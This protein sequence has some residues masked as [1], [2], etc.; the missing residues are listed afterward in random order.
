MTTRN[1]NTAIGLLVTVAALAAA[2]AADRHAQAAGPVDRAPTCTTMFQPDSIAIRQEPVT[3]G[4][5]LSDDIGRI[6]AVMPPE[7]SG[8]RVNTFSVQD[9]TLELET[10]RAVEGAWTL[11][12]I[13]DGDLTCSGMLNVLMAGDGQ[14]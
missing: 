11:N 7:D 3:I 9:Q 12:F 14:H 13:G 1:G 10:G 2:L 5:S 6:Q 8:I 4:Y